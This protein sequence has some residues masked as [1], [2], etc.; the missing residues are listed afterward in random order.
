MVSELV[1][2]QKYDDTLTPFVAI[3]RHELHANAGKGD[4]PGWLAMTRDEV[5]LEI[6]Y[7]L[8]K[9]QKA[10][11]TDDTAGIREYAAD[12]A[13]MSMM[14]VD[15]CG[16]W[17]ASPAP[18][19]AETE[20]VAKHLVFAPYKEGDLVVTDLVD[21]VLTVQ[22]CFDAVGGWRVIAQG[23]RDISAGNP[24]GRYDLS[25]TSIE[26]YSPAPTP[27]PTG[28]GEGDL[29]R[30]TSPIAQPTGEAGTPRSG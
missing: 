26:P 4:R 21:D 20:G 7:H 9:L 12:V 3:M 11:R 18:T 25:V 23:R 6:Y 5:L 16:A 17:L 22:D 19:S 29:G 13:N 15:I 1:G 2:A 8:A 28:D 27:P 14:A 24:S 10:V 30:P